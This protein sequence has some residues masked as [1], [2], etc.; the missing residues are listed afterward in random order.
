[1][2]KTDAENSDG[3][4]IHRQVDSARRSIES[5]PHW[6]HDI[7]RLSGGATMPSGGSNMTSNQFKSEESKK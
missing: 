7:T 3:K 1:M 4:W 2:K 6:M 5:W